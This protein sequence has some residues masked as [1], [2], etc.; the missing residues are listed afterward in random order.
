MLTRWSMCCCCCCGQAAIGDSNTAAA[1]FAYS[2]TIDPSCTLCATWHCC[3]GQVGIATTQPAVVVFHGPARAY[4]CSHVLPCGYLICMY[5]PL[6]ATR[7]LGIP[8]VIHAVKHYRWSW[9]CALNGD[10]PLRR[11]CKGK[12]PFNG[13]YMVDALSP[14]TALDRLRL[15]C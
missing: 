10:Q 15:V 7:L 3:M 1:A 8:S 12:V 4:G 6:I 13:V 2:Y 9:G 5:L 14:F 11:Y